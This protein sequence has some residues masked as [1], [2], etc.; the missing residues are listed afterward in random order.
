MDTWGHRE[1]GQWPAAVQ[2]DAFTDSFRQ[3]DIPGTML[4]AGLDDETLQEIG[5]KLSIH[6]RGILVAYKKLIDSQSSMQ[7]PYVLAVCVS[8]LVCVC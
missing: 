4:A 7:Q 6:R 8:V 1:V 2:L 3:N 5:V